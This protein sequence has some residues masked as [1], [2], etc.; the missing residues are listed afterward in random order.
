MKRNRIVINFDDPAAASGG[1][2]APRRRSSRRGIG[3]VLGVIAILLLLI[4][5]GL[6]AG[7]FFWWRHYQS[8]PAYS[9]ALLVDATQRNDQQAVDKILD[10]DKIATDFLA[11]I[12]AR[13]P[14]SAIWASQIDLTKM[15][16]SAKVKET[17]HDQLVKELQ[18]LTDVAADKPFVLIALAVPRFAE[19]K[20]ENNVAHAMVNLKDEPIQLTMV[21]TG[22]RWRV[23]AV[24]DERLARLL[25]QA[26][27][28]SLPMNGGHVQDELQRQLSNLPNL[29]R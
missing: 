17:L 11:Q 19:I 2:V 21:Q 25:A 24:Q 5:G 9:L 6:V 26:M 18:R 22:D 16:S 29:G 14:G 8:S 15:S 3:R 12:R 28:N 1:G 27:V 4:V 23:T 10:T 13:V 20:Q 7:G